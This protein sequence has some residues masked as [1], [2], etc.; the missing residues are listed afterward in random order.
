MGKQILITG[1]GRG[2]SFIAELLAA[3][4][5]SCGAPCE[6]VHVDCQPQAAVLTASRRRLC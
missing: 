1:A 5:A 3:K 2:K 4:Y 6:V